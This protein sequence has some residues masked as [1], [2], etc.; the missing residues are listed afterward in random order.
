MGTPAAPRVPAHTGPPI[1]LHGEIVGKRYRV[2]TGEPAEGGTA[3][4]R[5]RLLGHGAFGA[6]YKAFDVASGG[7]VALKLEWEDTKH[8]QLLI[9]YSLLSEMRG[10]AGVPRVYW[11]GTHGRCNA[12]AMQCLGP[13]VAG[14]GP[15]DG[16]VPLPLHYV[17][18][19]ARHVLGTLRML[20]L[21][22]FVHRDLKPENLLWRT[23]PG[24]AGT[25]LPPVF[26]IDY[27][28]SKR[29][30]D[31]QGK[32]HV[33][34]RTDKHLIGTPR[35]VG[36]RG[37]TGHE[38]S[39]RDDVESLGYV[40]VYLATGHLPWQHLDA[41]GVEAD[42]NYSSIG[43]MKD[44]VPLAELCKGLPA[45]FA[46]TIAYARYDVDFT[47]VPNYTLLDSLWAK[48][49][50]ELSAGAGAGVGAGAGAGAKHTPSPPDAPRE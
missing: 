26:L 36:H 16:K 14:T 12:M 31:A 25:P 23:A 39:R 48:A 30:Q 11:F 6:V 15:E 33:R 7:P 40:L 1:V 42:P 20:H 34:P 35:Y 28:L 50:I 13:A 3:P 9:E 43:R 4:A 47:A 24:P 32:H 18:H 38:L 44:R 27:G 41:D 45:A 49:A 8:P 37:H 5:H 21:A 22:G 2:W 19:I 46:R 10:V 29:V 17:V